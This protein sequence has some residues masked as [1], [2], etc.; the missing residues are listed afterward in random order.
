MAKV[1]KLKWWISPNLIRFL[2]AKVGSM[3]E[4]ANLIEVSE[5]QIYCIQRGHL[6][7]ENVMQNIKHYRD[8]YG[9]RPK[10]ES[11]GIYPD[12]YRGIAGKEIK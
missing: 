3:K 6:V 12:N 7:T 11:D 4:L 5:S 1:I 8:L 9:Y 10:Y 2:K